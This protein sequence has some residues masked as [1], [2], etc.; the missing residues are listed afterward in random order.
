MNMVVNEPPLSYENRK[1]PSIYYNSKE[2]VQIGREELVKKF[3][4]LLN[5]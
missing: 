4:E 2:L 5:L 1:F 3:V